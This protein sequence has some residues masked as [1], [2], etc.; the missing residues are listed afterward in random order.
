M[1]WTRESLLAA[2]LAL[3]APWAAADSLTVNTTTDDDASNNL[4]SLREAVEYFNRGRPEDGYQGCESAAHDNFASIKLPADTEPYLIENGPITIRTDLSVSGEG[5]TEDTVTTVQVVGANRAFI[6][7]H[8]P[9]YVAPRCATTPA[10]PC[11]TQASS[12]SLDPV[13]DSGTAGDYLTTSRAPAFKGTLPGE[14]DPDLQNKNY[15]VRVYDNPAEGDPVQVGQAIVTVPSSGAAAPPVAIPVDWTVLSSYQSDDGVH[16]Y[17]YTVQIVDPV[18]G[19]ELKAVAPGTG[20]VW[21]ALYTVPERID[22]TFSQMVIKGGCSTATDCAGLADDNTSITNDPVSTNTAYDTFALSFTHG[23]TGT[24]GNGG[25]FFTADHLALSDVLVQD[26]AAPNGGAVYVASDGVLD[27]SLTELRANR[28]DAGA[29]IYAAYNSVDLSNSLLT[30]NAV[31]TP[32]GSGAVVQV[33]SSTRPTGI[34]ATKITNVTISGNTGRALSLRA[35]AKVNVSTIVLNSGGGLDFNGENVG[36]FNTIIVGNTASGDCQNLPVT[37]DT[38]F[39][40]VLTGGSCPAATGNQTINDVAGTPGQLMA[41]LVN[42]KCLSEFGLL[43]PLADHGGSTFVHMPHILPGYG[44]DPLLLGASPIINKASPDI[45]TTG[46]ACSSQDQRGEDRSAYSCDIGAVEVQGVGASEVTRSGGVIKYGETYQQYLGDDL[47]D[48]ELL[49]ENLCPGGVSLIVPP[50]TTAALYPPA[51]LAPDPTRVV[52][53]TYRD[54]VPG[55]P[56][57]ESAPTR[58]TVTFDAD[59]NYLYQPRF[60]FHGFDLFSMRV[61]TTLSILN[62]LPA[63]HSHAVSARVIVEPD[64]A[65]VSDKLGG[66]LDVRGLLVLALLG[67]GRRRGGQE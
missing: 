33:A 46:A 7:Y 11:V 14:S 41:T 43:C 10:D 62:A 28:A 12:F 60:D 59:G 64:T 16:H 22:V 40:L 56:W 50:A 8:N 4:C 65:M 32:A 21:L 3:S 23:Q 47:A 63:D 9:Q 49:P 15:V 35:G 13:S 17:T 6:I 39:N 37:P 2:I 67:L 20:R 42:G 45:G 31:N 30:A 53:G 52:G 18:S 51:S 36:L 27:V 57:V 19:A 5:R 55:C 25:I 44:A 1:S 26:G 29:A 58:G 34:A 54:D 61:V 48:E 24:T 38:G 66:V